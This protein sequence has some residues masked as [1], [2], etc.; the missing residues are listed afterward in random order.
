MPTFRVLLLYRY[1]VHDQRPRVV[2][3]P[4][5][6]GAHPCCFSNH[7]VIVGFSVVAGVFLDPSLEFFFNCADK[8]TV[9]R[10]AQVS[11]PT[12]QT[13]DMRILQ[14]TRGSNYDYHRRLVLTTGN[15]CTG[16]YMTE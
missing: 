8:W 9:M 11:P 1:L 12:Q 13:A 10:S 14:T 2:G 5:V 3:I 15:I 16:T 4:A 6:A 7:T